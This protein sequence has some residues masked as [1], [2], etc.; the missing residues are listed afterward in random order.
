MTLHYGEFRI[1]YGDEWKAR[2]DAYRLPSLDVG[3]DASLGQVFDWYVRVAERLE[4][5]MR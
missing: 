5:K 3:P 1:G 4:V 2:D